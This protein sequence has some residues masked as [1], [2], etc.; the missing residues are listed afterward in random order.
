M[1]A[2]YAHHKET[3]Y[4]VGEFGDDF[5][6]YFVDELY[7]ELVFNTRIE[8]LWYIRN[9]CNQSRNYKSLWGEY[10]FI[11]EIPVFHLKDFQKSVDKTANP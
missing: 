10:L 8:A 1:F 3:V 9:I 5:E 2:I 6:T 11:Q 7:T 4:G